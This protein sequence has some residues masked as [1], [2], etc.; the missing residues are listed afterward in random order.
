MIATLKLRPGSDSEFE[1]W[2]THHDEVVGAFPGFVSSDIIPPTHKGSHEW[3]ILLNFR[4]QEDLTTWQKSS[5]RAEIISEGIP[6]FEGGTIGEVVQVGDGA[7]VREDTSVT[8]VVFSKIKPG[9]ESRYREWSVRI[10]SAQ[11]KYP[12]YRGMY[13]QPPDESGG[14][15]TTI[16]RF[17]KAAHLEGWL[18]AP[19]RKALLEES[20]DFI[21]HEQ[22]TRLATSFPGWIPIDPEKGQSPPD[23]KPA[24][25]VL[26]GLFP[27]VML[28]L[29]FL[30]PILSGL[31]LHASLA[32]FIGNAISVALTSFGTMPLFVK[33]FEWW[34]FPKDNQ[35]A[36]TTK[37]AILLCLL[38]AV[39]VAAFWKLLPW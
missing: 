36:V 39:E 26:L 9:L 1:V 14:L 15:W 3:T 13:L 20:K 19:E 21:E 31:G 23:W 35:S 38:F 11:A 12:G 30:S 32:T 5:Q 6:F 33:W 27:I 7:E 25:L 2:K 8:E 4:T 10:Q 29:K 16:I 24:M 22:L 18:E 37:G 28:Q 17:D 34:L